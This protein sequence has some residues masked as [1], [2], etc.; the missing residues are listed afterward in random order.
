MPG[1]SDNI[2]Y[3]VSNLKADDSSRDIYDD[4]AEDYDRHLKRDFG[5][6]SP[7]VAATELA[8]IVDR[9]DAEI[10][11]YGCGTGL[12]GEALRKKGFSHIDG[13]DV[14]TGMLEQAG[15]KKVYRELV[16][17]DLTGSIPLADETYDAALCIG[18]M[19][20]GHV[21]AQ[22]V[23]EMLRPIRRGGAFVII[24]NGSYYQS[25]GF[26]AGFR[27]IEQAELWSIRK[28]EEFNYMSELD[29]PG[30]LLVAKRR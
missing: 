1:D 20:A 13:I 26:E 15:A 24:L 27:G 17:A 14:S 22:H 30:W 9:T 10:M 7:Q 25:G 23:A 3:R 6:L 12:V 21:G 18:S 19:G 28:L 11:D 29:R 8:A 5:Y 4:W 2:L 16:C